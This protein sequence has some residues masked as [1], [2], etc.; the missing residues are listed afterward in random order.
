MTKEDYKAL[1]AYAVNRKVN[2]VGTMEKVAKE[3]GVTRQT[4]CNW[5]SGKVQI[6]FYIADAYFEINDKL[7]EEFSHSTYCLT[8]MMETKM[9]VKD[10]K[11]LA[12][13]FGYKIKL[14]KVD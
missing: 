6:P 4:I 3:I 11:D 2:E 7:K 5:K 8:Q 9:P 12:E 13:K 10:F 1:V 14:V